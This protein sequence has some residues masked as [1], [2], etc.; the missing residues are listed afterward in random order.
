MN[1]YVAL[2]TEQGVALGADRTFDF[3]ETSENDRLQLVT[4]STAERR[5]NAKHLWDR[6]LIICHEITETF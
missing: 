1:E 3:F 6:A 4:P 2:D 5:V